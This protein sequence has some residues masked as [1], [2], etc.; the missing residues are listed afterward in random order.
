MIFKKPKLIL[1]LFFSLSFFFSFN[2]FNK[3][4][5]ET[6]IEI[7]KGDTINSIS[8]KL[9][10][11]EA[12]KS[13]TLFIYYS[14]ILFKLNFFNLFQEGE[15]LLNKNETTYSFLKK[16]NNGNVR[17]YKITFPEGITNFQ[18]FETLNNNPFFSDEKLAVNQDLYLMP[19][20]FS[21]PR[22]TKR[23]TILQKSHYQMEQLLDIIWDKL[24]SNKKKILENKKNMYILA[25]II[26]REFLYKEEAHLIASVYLNRLKIKMKLQADPTVIYSITNGQTNMSRRLTFKDL[27]T[28]SPFNTYLNYGLPPSAISIPSQEA[29]ISILEAK[30]SEDLFFVLSKDGRRHIFTKNFNDHINFANLYRN[31]K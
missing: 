1:L 10:K 31:N 22:N 17:F 20:T 3:I 18:F 12:I 30:E 2:N 9:K 14:K 8:S 28:K 21:F 19:E 15:Y 11:L 4:E 6:V 29:V 13:E 16:I 25:S 7:E 24:P 26:E 5:K 27:K 23:K